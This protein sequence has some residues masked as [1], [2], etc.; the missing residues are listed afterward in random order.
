MRWFRKAVLAAAGLV[1][2]V[3][4]AGA[5]SAAPALWVV[6]DADP[7]IYLFGTLHALDPATRWRTPAYDAALARADTV[8]FE[9]DLDTADP[10]TI[11]NILD[12]YGVDPAR[13]LSGK[14]PPRDLAALS[15]HVDVARIDHLRPWAAALMLSMQP[16]LGRGA[17]V[18]A[19]A[20]MTVTRAARQTSKTIRAFE[21]LEDQARLFAG[22]SEPAEVAYLTDVIRQRSE[23]PKLT[24]RRRE[25]D[26]ERAWAAGDLA[27]LGPALVDELRSGNPGLYEALL[28]RRNLQWA[29]RLADEMSGGGRGTG[30]CGRP[31]HGRRRG[32][33]RLAGRPRLRRHAHPIASRPDILSWTLDRPFVSCFLVTKTRELAM[34]SRRQILWSLVPAFAA[35]ALGLYALAG[36][37]LL[38]G[39]DALQAVR[40]HEINLATVLGTAAAGVSVAAFR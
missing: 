1:S 12:R 37:A 34:R 10:R 21:T 35:V 18:E 38:S 11:A 2:G 33:A 5:A 29:D 22:L 13:P 25:G 20:D 9:A 26:L 27:T 6:K 15:R 3:L 32:P 19:G 17:R 8:W 7:E 23:G 14:L 16:M 31:A 39:G 40:L 36:A 4:V 30:Q 24:L 28:K